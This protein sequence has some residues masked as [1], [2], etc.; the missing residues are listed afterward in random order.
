[1][2]DVEISVVVPMHNEEGNVLELYKEIRQSMD[3]YGRSYEM[4]FVNDYSSDGTL[5]LLKDLSQTDKRFHF[6]DLLSN[7]G[8]NWAVFAGISKSTGKIIVTIDGDIQNDPKYIPVLVNK[9]KEGFKVVSGWREHRIGF[10]ARLAP[11]FVANKFI[12]L[13]SGIKVHDT[14]CT[15]KAYRSEIIKDVYVPKGFNN[16]FS[17]AVF[18]IAN[19]DFAEVRVPDRIRKFGVSHY[20]LERIFIV[21]NDLLAIPFIRRRFNTPLADINRR[22]LYAILFLE[23]LLVSAVLIKGFLFAV[24]F[25]VLIMA[26]FSI[27]RNIKRFIECEHNP[28]FI[29]K[30]FI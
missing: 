12:S 21:F 28:K 26:S 19:K 25:L 13:V 8:E 30:E 17:P 16:R 10:F 7:V 9:L 1:M 27:R 23:L 14:G 4:I 6:C 29:I 24:V 22:V 3:S 18:N 11:S 2:K 5:K 15:L 20:G